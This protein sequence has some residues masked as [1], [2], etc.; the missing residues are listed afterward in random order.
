MGRRAFIKSAAGGAALGAIA[1]ALETKAPPSSQALASSRAFPA[2]FWWGVT[3]AAYQVE[4]A[5]GED[6]RKPS[7]WDTFSHTP[8]KIAGGDTG[9]VSCDH[10]HRFREDVKL[11]ADSGAKHF[12]FSL[13]WP[14]ILPDGRGAV[15]E[16]GL[17]HY[18]RVVDELLKHG[19]TPHATLYHWDLPQALQDRYRG[20]QSREI[21]RD[22]ADYAQ[23]VAARL[24]DRIRHWMTLN[25]ICTF[26][27]LG[28]GVGRAVPHAPGLVL[29]RE[30]D[31]WQIVHHA[32]LAH[33]LACQA[34]RAASKKPCHV[35][36]AEGMLAY[37]PVVETPG[38]IEAVRLAFRRSEVNGAIIV[39]LLT[40]QYD[41]FWLEQRGKEAPD[42][43]AGDMETIH[44][45]LD[46]IGFN[47][48]NG[49]YVRAADNPAGFEELPMFD[50]FPNMN[51]GWL[52]V[53]PECIYWGIRMTSEL[54]GRQLPIVIT[55]N[56]CPDGSVPGP[57][58]VV[59][60]T[61]RVMYLR[62][63]LGQVQRA[64]AEGYP[65]QGYFPWSLLD[66]FE[67]AEGYGKR[68]GLV[69]VDY[70]TQKR[71]PK[72]SYRWYQEVVRA[73]RVM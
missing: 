18:E 70:E 29:S 21:T 12:R 13:A 39:P 51:L 16:R 31:V 20:W 63:Y 65:V 26:T 60:D 54:S 4:G 40:G 64:V 3:T 56:G 48:Y 24:G 28:Y 19:I 68:F 44:Q 10:Y 52:K 37:I 6:G 1:P 55:E 22:F 67:W 15:N 62:A 33:G 57:D 59:L 2:G 45:R 58:G 35:S 66:N 72:L 25:E 9:D 23:T 34:L 42:V 8:G 73:G 53:T 43:R 11:I 5:V 61:D 69:H 17:D 7:I 14:R 32:L 30:K 38:E 41:P 46:T 50:G 71:T 49:S 27:R 47:N 36:I